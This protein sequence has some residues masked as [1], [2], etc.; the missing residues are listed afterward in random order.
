MI[1]EQ[2]RPILDLTRHKALQ[3]DRFDFNYESLE[4]I[5]NFPLQQ[6]KPFA[7]T[8]AD[9]V[10]LLMEY[11]LEKIRQ[12]V[13]KEFECENAIDAML[14]V[15]KEIA[16]QYHEIFPSL[17]PQIMANYPAEYHEQF[18]KRMDLVAEKIHF[19][20]ERGIAQGLYRSDL[21]PEL[22]SRLYL[23]RLIDI[24]NQ[25]CFPMQSFSFNVL[26]Y[27]MFESLIRSIGTPEGLVY[28]DKQLETHH[29]A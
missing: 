19:N 5:S 3:M 29:L 7:K 9:L 28:L 13:D 22:I 21:S 25:D 27:Q 23:S 4:K 17:S 15:S 24:H 8:P 11:E 12:I 16:K 14:R 26:F 1:H 10:R 20:L 18:E 6:L 2:L